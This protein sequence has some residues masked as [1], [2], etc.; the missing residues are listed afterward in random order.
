ME[1]WSSPEVNEKMG[2]HMYNFFNLGFNHFT[3]QF[4][5]VDYPLNDNTEFLD[6]SV[7]LEKVPRDF[8]PFASY[9]EG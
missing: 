8:F 6:M 9:I 3:S 1:L 4:V 5:D 2:V 7:T